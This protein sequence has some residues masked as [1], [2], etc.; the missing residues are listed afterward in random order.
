MSEGRIVGF[1]RETHPFLVRD[2]RD[3][4]SFYSSATDRPHENEDKIAEYLDAGHEH[5]YLSSRPVLKN[6]ED[7]GRLDRS[8]LNLTDGVW[9]WPSELA[10][11]VREFHLALPDDFVAHMEANAW[12]VPEDVDCDD[13]MFPGAV[14]GDV[15][16]EILP[17][18]EPSKGK[19]K[20]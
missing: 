10:Y 1:Y 11:Y 17:I 4:P 12:R 9:I 14:P 20:A 7:R 15:A 18:E 2:T 8:G 6:A 19:A 16:P 5:D 3:L 13:L